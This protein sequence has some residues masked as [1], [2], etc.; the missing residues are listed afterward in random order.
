MLFRSVLRAAEIDADII[1]LA[2]RVDGIYSDDPEKNPEAKKYDSLNYNDILTGRLGV[3]D[4]TA[5]SLS[6]DNNI[7]ILV[8]ALGDG[9]GIV[10]ALSG[11]KLGTLVKGG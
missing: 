10:E 9:S 4:S 11:K 5:A 8:F 2:K 7:A 3:M 6:M 1:L